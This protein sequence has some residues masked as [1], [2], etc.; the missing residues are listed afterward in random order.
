MMMMMMIIIIIIII[1]IK[2]QEKSHF[3]FF[4]MKNG[5][6][7]KYYICRT[8]SLYHS[9]ISIMRKHACSFD[10]LELFFAKSE[11]DEGDEDEG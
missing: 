10:N 8:C 7:A 3:D 9:T 11:D 1:I 5:A 6:I 4:L 2:T